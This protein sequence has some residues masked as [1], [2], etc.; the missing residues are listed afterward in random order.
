MPVWQARCHG[1]CTRGLYEEARQ[2]AL[3]YAGNFWKRTIIFLELQDHGIPDQR[4]VNQQLL[5][6]SEE[7]RIPLVATNDVHYTYEE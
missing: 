1:I 5:R 4:L 7:L 6:M 3:E 2:T